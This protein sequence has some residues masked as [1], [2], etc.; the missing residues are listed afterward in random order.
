M[1]NRRK[2]GPAERPITPKKTRPTETTGKFANSNAIGINRPAMGLLLLAVVLAAI[3]FAYGKYLEFNTKDAF[4]SALNIYSAQCIANGRQLGVEVFPSAMPAT[5]LVNVIGVK[6]FGFSEFGPKFIQMLFQLAALVLMFYTLGRLYGNFPA[7][8]A[9]ILAAFYL[10]CPPFAKFGNVKEQ[11]MI[12]C[13]IIAGCGLMLHYAGGSWWWLIVSGAA[14]GNIYYFKPTGASAIIAMAVFMLVQLIPRRRWA[15]FGCDLASLLIGAV[16]GLTP[17]MIFYAGQKQMAVLFG[18]LTG[19]LFIKMLVICLVIS[20][21]IWLFMDRRAAR[22]TCRQLKS[23][24]GGI[25]R[26]GLMLVA[27][28]FGLCVVGFALLPREDRFMLWWFLEDLH[29]VRLARWLRLWTV[30][31]IKL[32]ISGGGYLTSSRAVTDFSSLYNTVFGYYQSFVVPIGAG[33]LA[34]FWRVHGLIVDLVARRKDR[35]QRCDAEKSSPGTFCYRESFVLL[36]GLWWILDMLFVWVSPRSYVQYFLPLNASAAMLTAYVLYR[37]R[38]N[39]MGFVWLL[40]AWLIVDLLLK[41]VILSEVFPYIALRSSDSMGAYWKA[42]FP[43]AIPLVVAAVIGLLMRKKQFQPAR[44]VVLGLICCGMFFWWNTDNLSMFKTKVSD[45]RQTRQKGDVNLWEQVAY[46]VRN[47][48]SADDGL[49]VWGWYPGIYFQAQRFSPTVDP[50]EANLHTYK[51]QLLKSKARQIVEQLK[52]DPPKFIVDPQHW[53]YPYYSNP[54]I[55]LWPRW[56]SRDKVRFDLR[57][58]TSSPSYSVEYCTIEDVIKYDK[59]LIEQVGEFAYR[60]RTDP[61]RPSGPVGPDEAGRLAQ[62]EMARHQ[63]MFSLREFIMT[64]YRP[65]VPA[66]AGMFIFLHKDYSK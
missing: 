17:L 44:M 48:S 9:L 34:I 47:N 63:A 22:W 13:M 4:D 32:Y 49:Y 10:S 33:L 20:F 45:L 50:A 54:V 15:D 36:L 55:D 41:C 27:A 30:E 19:R 62:E 42:F 40:A 25:W 3:P 52:A 53:L 58:I 5:L 37:C 60:Q 38:K 56:R 8:V 7:A 24:R 64:N 46:Y 39:P 35:R 28:V 23:V 26:I 6:L 31:E 66:N 16:L 61:R 14:A 43:R 18:G 29:V 21:V 1:A 12:A 11:F 57:V 65:V 2:T 51:P 59:Q